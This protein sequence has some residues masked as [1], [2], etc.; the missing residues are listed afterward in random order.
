MFKRTDYKIMLLFDVMLSVTVMSSCI[1]ESDGGCVQYA[2]KPYLV[3]SDGSEHSDTAVKSI[4][5]YLFSG[6]KFS[7]EIK[8]ESDGRFLVSFDGTNTTTLV[9][10]GYPGN[11]SL[12]VNTPK[13]GDDIS[14]V[15]AAVLKTR[16]NLSPEGFY[17]GCF[18][19]VPSTLDTI[20]KEVNIAM[21]PERATMQVVIENLH[22]RYGNGGN[23]S[24]ELNGLRSEIEFDGTIDGDSI[25]YTPKTSFDAKDNLC[26]DIVNTLPTKKGERVDVALYRDGIF[27]WQIS[28]DN[29]GKDLTLSG[30]DNKIVVIDALRMTLVTFN[31]SNINDWNSTSGGS[32]TAK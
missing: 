17:Y 26:S 2:A 7:H 21:H 9:M 4:T 8:A 12:N 31:G 1:N 20:S 18:N 19:Y 10:F 6:G 5:A 23:Y 30:G 28:E 13:E 27:M 3:G 32:A 22:S 25:T 14:E 29:Q 15:S 11:D 24:I 16:G